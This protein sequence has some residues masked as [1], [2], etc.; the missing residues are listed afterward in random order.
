MAAS[1]LHAVACSSKKGEEHSPQNLFL[2]G[3]KYSLET[4]VEFPLHFLV[5]NCHRASR[6]AKKE[7]I[8]HFLPLEKK[9]SSD[10]KKEEVVEVAVFCKCASQNE[11]PMLQH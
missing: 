8:W 2:E 9:A 3:E 7:N 6:K 4:Q 5:Q 11:F 1:S 10:S